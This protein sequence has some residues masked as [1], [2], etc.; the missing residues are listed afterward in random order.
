MNDNNTCRTCFAAAMALLEKEPAF[1]E[2]TG[3][4]VYKVSVACDKY[5][6][7]VP[8][9]QHCS[10]CRSGMTLYGI[11][12]ADQ[13]GCREK[14]C[15]PSKNQ[16]NEYISCERFDPKQPVLREAYLYWKRRAEGCP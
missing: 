6:H 16:V 9:F 3:L 14:M 15:F 5:L 1:C 10:N 12:P 8:P 4:H 7:H 2:W 11:D 13:I